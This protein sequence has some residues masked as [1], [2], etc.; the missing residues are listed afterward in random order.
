MDNRYYK[1]GCPALMHDGRFLT[2]YIHSRIF[3]QYVRNMNGIDSIQNFK[4]FLQHNGDT[5]LNNQRA[6]LNELNTCDVSGK[7]VPLSNNS[8]KYIEYSCGCNSLKLPAG[9]N[10]IENMCYCKSKYN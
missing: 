7:C 9:V 5:I 1:Y 8:Q 4:E 6:T 10:N 2:N 3:D